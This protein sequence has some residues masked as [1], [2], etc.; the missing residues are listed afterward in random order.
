MK[1]AGENTGSRRVLIHIGFWLAWV[2]GFTMLQS[3]GQGYGSFFLWFRYYLITLPVFVIHTYIIAYWLIPLTFFKKKYGLLILGISV[4]LMV[5]SI[6]EL[7]ISNELVF[8]PYSPEKAFNPGYLNVQNIVISGI[9][10][11]YI[12]LV[13]LAVKVG[14]AWYRAQHIKNEEQ[15]LNEE[16]GFEIYQYQLQPRLMLHLMELLSDA[17][18]KKPE[19]VSTLIIRISDFLN[20]FLK[21]NHTN[22]VPV[23]AETKLM[24]DFFEIH[25]MVLSSRLNGGIKISGNLT[26]FVAPSF[27]FL[28]VLD[29]ALNSGRKCNDLFDCVVFLK[30]AVRKLYFSLELW[31]GKEFNFCCDTDLEILKRRLQHSFPGNYGLK[32]ENEKNFRMVQIEIFF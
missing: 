4:F 21:E 7:V 28:P 5:F 13:F 26:P 6:L 10:N 2:V 23:T 3:L 27:L 32:E 29:F 9:G 12:I 31:S 24:D 22:W 25:K 1:W 8:K 20:H 19:I 16:T 17:I 18:Q 30:G 11:H 15:R 14:Q